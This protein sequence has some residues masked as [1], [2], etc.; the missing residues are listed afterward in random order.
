MLGYRR[1][2]CWL[3]WFSRGVCRL[4]WW[5]VQFWFGCQFGGGN[6]LDGSYVYVVFWGELFL[7]VM[8]FV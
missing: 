2:G 5:G 7:R 6:F 4:G 1:V 3:G 8:N